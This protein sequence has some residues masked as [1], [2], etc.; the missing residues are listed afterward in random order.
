MLAKAAMF[1]HAENPDHISR[2]RRLIWVSIGWKCQKYGTFSNAAAYCMYN[3]A[4]YARNSIY[5]I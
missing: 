3:D 2:I 5:V 4:S 1:L